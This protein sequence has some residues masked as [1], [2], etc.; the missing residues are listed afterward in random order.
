MSD[1]NDIVTQ[2]T[3][4]LG[5]AERESIY[6]ADSDA[7]MRQLIELCLCI[8]Q[9]QTQTQKATASVTF[10]SYVIFDLYQYMPI[11]DMHKIPAN[12]LPQLMLLYAV[13]NSAGKELSKGSFE[14]AIYNSPSAMSE[15]QA[16]PEDYF[17]LLTNLLG[18][19]KGPTDDVTLELT[20]VPYMEVD[21]LA[22]QWPLD[23]SM[24]QLT[25]HLLRCLL[26]LR[27]GHYGTAKLE[28]ERFKANV[29]RA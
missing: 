5:D 2:L 8:V 18:V 14:S 22:T 4:E 28:L 12:E 1:Y 27:I 9:L 10:P 20:Y 6:P 13:R 17:T 3:Y 11:V 25:L 26:F 15:S 21:S 7:L 24:I 16:L 23:E 29:R 19:R